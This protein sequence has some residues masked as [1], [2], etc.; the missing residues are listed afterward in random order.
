[1]KGE[2]GGGGRPFS[3]LVEMVIMTLAGELKHRTLEK[4]GRA[5]TKQLWPGLKLVLGPRLRL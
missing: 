5:N 4:N 2:G 1:M 3:P